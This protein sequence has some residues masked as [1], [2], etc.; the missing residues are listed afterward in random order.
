M[1]G[2]KRINHTD[3]LRIQGTLFNV[4][5]HH[6]HDM[7]IKFKFGAVDIIWMDLRSDSFPEL[8]EMFTI[9]RLDLQ[10][11][12]WACLGLDFDPSG[13]AFSFQLCGFDTWEI[14]A[15]TLKQLLI[16]GIGNVVA[17]S[18]LPGVSLA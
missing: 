4:E 16:T 7:L 18:G 9:W 17:T 10:L 15:S 8:V 2:R 5:W 6:I 13:W 11:L 1:K 12:R 14:L 3:W